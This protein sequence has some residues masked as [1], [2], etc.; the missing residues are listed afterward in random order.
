MQMMNIIP[1][2]NTELMLK[3]VEVNKKSLIKNIIEE[4]NKFDPKY[5]TEL[6]KKFQTTG[7]C[8]YGYK[9]RFAHGKE[10]LI[11]KNQGKNYKKRFC[12]SFH[13]KGYCPYGSR[14][15]FRHDERNFNETN[16]S[17]YYFRLFLFKNYFSESSLNCLPSNGTNLI[18]DRLPVFKSITQNLSKNE[19]F[20]KIKETDKDDFFEINF[21]RKYSQST[22]SNTSYE[23]D[24]KLNF[25]NFN[26]NEINFTNF[27]SY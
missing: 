25:S 21:Q 11:I 7:K 26:S 22:V 23:D 5:K 15:N 17:Y 4:E 10:E 3:L 18:K 1:Q 12:K 14:C 6:C 13:E 8:P 19:N 9:C 16:L 20:S 24:R 2:L 27:K